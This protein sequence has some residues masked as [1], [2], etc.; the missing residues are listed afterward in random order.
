MEDENRKKPNIFLVLHANDPNAP[1]RPQIIEVF[2]KLLPKKNYKTLL[3][4]SWNKNVNPDI[5]YGSK[6]LKVIK[7][8]KEHDFIV[9]KVIDRVVNSIRKI[10]LLNKLIDSNEDNIIVVRNSIIDSLVVLVGGGHNSKKVFQYSFA[11]HEYVNDLQRESRSIK[12]FISIQ[13]FKIK[14]T[15]LYYSMRKFDLVLPMSD[16]IAK[17]LENAGIPKKKMHIFPMGVN[18]EDFNPSIHNSN[19]RDLSDNELVIGYI[20]SL[21][22]ER[23]LNLIIDSLRKL[24]ESKIECCLVLIG[25][26]SGA[27]ELE[28]RAKELNLE[29]YVRFVGR[30]PYMEIPSCILSFDIALCLNSPIPSHMSTRSTKLMEYM[31]MGKPVITNSEI[32]FQRKVIKESGGGVQIGYNADEL[33]KALIY[34]AKSP[35]KREL[36]GQKGKRYVVNNF[37][38]NKISE[39]LEKVLNDLIKG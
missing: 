35:K 5:Y 16:I 2:C 4:F 31:A 32:P 12:N 30:V 33:S 7:A 14:S 19:L 21:G 34:L 25:A 13:Y 26:G 22:R 3:I 9:R 15:L 8:G 1:L 37:S 27:K 28:E 39:S 17:D 38:Y 6:N 20:G 10:I 29:G 36:M 18:E 23:N 11:I 24:R